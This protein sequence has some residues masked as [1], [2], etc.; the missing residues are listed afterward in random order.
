MAR[1]NFDPKDYGVSATREEFADQVVDFFR[2][3]LSGPT[4]R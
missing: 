3:Y 4:D 1:G 2:C